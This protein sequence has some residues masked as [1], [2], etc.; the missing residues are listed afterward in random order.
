MVA[1]TPEVVE[2]P[3][4]A[5][6]EVPKTAAVEAP[7]MGFHSAAADAQTAAPSEVA[8]P[9]DPRA[10]INVGT[11]LNRVKN[12]LSNLKVANDQEGTVA[13]EADP[14]LTGN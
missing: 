10:E 5:A 1:R 6:V 7:E 12:I 4:A 11:S 2:A 9:S 8:I 14:V 13:A 3:K